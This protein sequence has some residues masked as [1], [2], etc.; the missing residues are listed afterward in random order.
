V[1]TLSL[2][3]NG[4]AFGWG[5]C[6]KYIAEELAKKTETRLLPKDHPPERVEGKVLHAIANIL[7]EPIR[8]V[9]GDYNAGYCFFEMDLNEEAVKN[10]M[11]YDHIFCGST[12]NV[13]TLEQCDIFHTSLLLQGVD[14]EIFSPAPARAPDGKFVIFS[15]GKFEYRKGQDLVLAAFK[16]LMDKYP[17]LHL[18]TVWQNLW[19]ITMDTMMSSN[20]IEYRATGGTWPELMG[21]LCENNGIPPERVTHHGLCSQTELAEIMAGTDL[22]LF[23]NRCEGG[24]NL[25]LMEYMAR[26]RP[27]VASYN[28]GHI[29]VLGFREKR[30]NA[31]VMRRQNRRKLKPYPS[32]DITVQW[33]EPELDELIEK[34]EWAYHNRDALE[35]YADAAHKTTKDLTWEGTASTII[36]HFNNPSLDKADYLPQR[37]I[38]GNLLNRMGYTGEGAE[39]GVYRGGLSQFIHS[40]WLG[41]KLH[42]IDR[43]REVEG[44]CDITNRP[45]VE[46]DAICEKVK[47]FF[48]NDEDVNIIR[49]DSL[50]AARGFGDGQL[51]WVYIDADHMDLKADL[52]AWVP[53]VRKGGLV[54]GHDYYNG[55]NQFAKFQ[56]KRDVDEFVAQGSYELKF[57]A[58]DRN[59][60]RTWYFVK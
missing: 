39:I 31:L 14:H 29:D 58:D 25:M 50:N 60:L 5:V 53:K 51:D 11:S 59:L 40:R 12:Y 46:Q 16:I 43:W 9:I 32:L 37:Y 17:D 20:L 22:G 44:H 54:A 55:E 7:F 33:W 52:E 2:G 23:P 8:P 27:V 4:G 36:D 3:Q 1:L 41:K 28:S 15:G 26:R 13:I 10:A 42:L 6:S 56:V 24:T 18:V 38:F 35:F 48:K 49:D 19:D 47:E 57:S 21:S 34:I 45:Q 30:R